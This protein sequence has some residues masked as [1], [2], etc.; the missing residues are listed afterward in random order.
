MTPEEVYNKWHC[1]LKQ[2]D[3]SVFYYHPNLERIF[4]CLSIFV[5]TTQPDPHSSIR[6]GIPATQITGLLK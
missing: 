5:L 2:P 3:D 1:T 6:F 4:L